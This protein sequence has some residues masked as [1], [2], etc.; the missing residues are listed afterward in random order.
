MDRLSYF[1]QKTGNRFW[2][3]KINDYLPLIYANLS[4]KEF[5]TLIEWYEETEEKQLIGECNI[6]LIS[7]LAGF[8]SGNNLDRI[9]QC[10][11]YAGYS[12]LL[13]GWTL[14]RMG[15]KNA[16]FSIDINPDVT[17]FTLKW[18][19][20]A[21]LEDVVHLT[22]GDSADEK[23]VSQSIDYFN[24]RTPKAIFIDSSHQYKHTLKELKLWFHTLSPSGLLFLHDISDYAKTFDS[25]EE[26]GVQKAVDEWHNDLINAG[27]STNTSS[28]FSCFQKKT[29]SKPNLQ[30]A[31]LNRSKPKALGAEIPFQ[32]ICGLGIIQK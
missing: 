19:R 8:I 15:K 16:L 31:L 3:F 9:V 17:Q 23:I 6:P 11:H 27:E 14:R 18:I 22:I 24:K 5:N 10:G 20:K 4:S 13:L 25:T 1:K 7:T 12:T 21:G 26:G 29:S 2:W 30:M 32:D 28:F